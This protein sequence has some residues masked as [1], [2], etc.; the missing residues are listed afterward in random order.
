MKL[1]HFTVIAILV[2]TAGPAPA[3]AP[4]KKPLAKWT[5]EEFLAV[6]DQFKPKVVYWATAY[7]QGGKPRSAVI[8]IDGT[9]TV[10]PAIIDSCVKTPKSS[11]W[12]TLK[13]EWKK[14]EATTEKNVKEVEK[15]M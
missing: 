14:F 13:G 15:S 3:A 5:C 8:D 9:E 2:A 12:Q 10:T 11:F 7:S 4:A 1:A 6:D